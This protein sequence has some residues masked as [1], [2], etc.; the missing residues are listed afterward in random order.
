MLEAWSREFPGWDPVAHRLRSAF[1]SR[2]VRFHALPESKRY[3]DDEEE[4]AIILGRQNRVLGDLLG[5][6]SQ[7]VLLTTCH[8]GPKGVIEVGL[9]KEATREFDREARPWRDVAMHDLDEGFIEPTRWHVRA[10]RWSW[11]PGVF[12]PLL[13]LAALGEVANVMIVSPECRWLFHPYDGGMDVILE[14]ARA[15]DNLKA[16]YAGWLSPRPDGL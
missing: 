3:P 2:W 6:G 4:F 11:R 7:V 10:S 16:K 8:S 15:R 9:D 13:R 12:D 14:S 1:P 5:S